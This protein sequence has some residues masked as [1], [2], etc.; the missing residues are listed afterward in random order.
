MTPGFLEGCLLGE[1]HGEEVYAS[2]LL[3]MSQEVCRHQ[4]LGEGPDRGWK[5]GK[6]PWS[7]QGLG[8]GLVVITSAVFLDSLPSAW[9]CHRFLWLLI[10]HRFPL[11]DVHVQ[12][13]RESVGTSLLLPVN[14]CLCSQAVH[15][16]GWKMSSR[17]W[18]WLG[19]G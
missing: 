4:T 1:T 13:I 8:P 3:I 16:A 11:W 17:L 2:L 5:T 10:G 6:A 14:P 12:E 19:S 7:D 15:G 9:G 18:G